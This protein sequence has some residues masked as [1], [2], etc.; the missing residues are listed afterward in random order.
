MKSYRSSFPLKL[1]T[2]SILGL[3][4]CVN[5]KASLPYFG[6]NTFSC[7]FRSRYCV[8]RT[9]ALPGASQ[10][11]TRIRLSDCDWLLKSLRPET[12]VY[13]TVVGRSNSGH[14]GKHKSSADLCRWRNKSHTVSPII[15]NSTFI[16]LQLP[17]PVMPICQFLLVP[18]PKIWFSVRQREQ[19]RTRPQASALVFETQDETAAA[20][21]R[22]RSVQVILAIHL[23][24]KSEDRSFLGF[25]H[26]ILCIHEKV[27]VCGEW[28]KS[29]WAACQKYYTCQ[30]DVMPGETPPSKLF[31]VTCY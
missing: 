11:P 6:P 29:P 19:G 1:H 30:T 22:R 13:M 21:S 8:T 15:S 3:Y 4:Q 7:L 5:S 18:F 9:L 2:N 24:H 28:N 10:Q 25:S 14:L 26:F 12:A 31:G 27:C 20:A 16:Q 23:P 17:A